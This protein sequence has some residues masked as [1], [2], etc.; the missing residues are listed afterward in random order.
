MWRDEKGA[1]LI[2]VTWI[3]LILSILSAVVLKTALATRELAGG[4]E[5][6]VRD[7]LIAESAM[8]LFLRR[9]FYDPDERVFRSGIVEVFGQRVTVDVLR[10]SGKI[11]LNR[12]SRSL[13]SAVFAASGIEEDQSDAFAARII[14]W[15]DGDSEPIVGGAEQADYQSADYYYGPRN[16]PMESVGELSFILDLEDSD[17]RCVEPLFTVHS[18]SAEIDQEY[19]SPEVKQVYNWAFL[20]D[21]KGDVWPDLDAVVPSGIVGSENALA[22]AALRLILTFGDEPERSYT[23]LV[24]YRSAADGSYKRLGDIKPYTTYTR[25]ET[26]PW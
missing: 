6:D 15:R 25:T 13:L 9:Y 19:A 11:N 8:E 22:G 24:R 3:V 2:V 23:S 18:L 1:A 7:R 21:W 4:L 10:E 12:A 16:G 26:C 5:R 20:R 14:D 17:F